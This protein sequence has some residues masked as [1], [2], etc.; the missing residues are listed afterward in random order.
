MVVNTQFESIVRSNVKKETHVQTRP[1]Y[2]FFVSLLL[3]PCI[4]KS[5]T[6][7][8]VEFIILPYIRPGWIHGG[9]GIPEKKYLEKN[10]AAASLN[11]EK[12]DYD[13]LIM[14]NS[15]DEFCTLDKAPDCDNKGF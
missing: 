8:D 7:F 2:P 15:I 3:N 13:V 14:K 4:H 6:S 11:K 9:T 10:A 12:K 1:C 5:S